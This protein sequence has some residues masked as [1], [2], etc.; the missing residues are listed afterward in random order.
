MSDFYT[1]SGVYKNKN[2]SQHVK[3]DGGQQLT[4]TK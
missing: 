2:Y 3:T 1:L 4:V